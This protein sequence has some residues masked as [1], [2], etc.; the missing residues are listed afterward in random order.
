MRKSSL[1]SILAVL[2]TALTLGTTPVQAVDLWGSDLAYQ[3]IISHRV[4]VAPPSSPQ[5][6]GPATYTPY[7]RYY[8]GRNGL[9]IRLNQRGTQ[10]FISAALTADLALL[11][12][13]PK[14]I[15]GLG[16]ISGL[17]LDD[18]L[19]NKAFAGKCLGVTVPPRAIDAYLERTMTLSPQ[20]FAPL[21]RDDLKA[22]MERCS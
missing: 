19:N 3:Q 10:L 20:T 1:L 2:I 4:Y 5:A 18:W 17:P 12:G 6:D 13:A 8:A 16:A 7:G 21:G 14:I 22:W 9:E 11:G 15:Q